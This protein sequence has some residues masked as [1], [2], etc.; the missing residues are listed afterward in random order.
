VVGR[1]GSHNGVVIVTR[2]IGRIDGSIVLQLWLLA[3]Q[4]HLAT[5]VL[6]NFAVKG[7]QNG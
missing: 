2:Q 4:H 1:V 6:N 5:Y 7:A 3:S